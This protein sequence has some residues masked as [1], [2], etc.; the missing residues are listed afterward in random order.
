MSDVA[1]VR[2]GAAVPILWLAAAGLTLL[3]LTPLS[4]AWSQAPDLGHGWA[5]PLLIGYLLWERWGERPVLREPAKLGAIWWIGAVVVAAVALPM[6][7]LLVPYPEWP[8]LVWIYT[9]LLVGIGLTT[10][11]VLAACLR[12]ASPRDGG[13][14]R[15]DD[16]GPDQPVDELPKRQHGGGEQQLI[17][18]ARPHRWPKR[19]CSRFSQIDRPPLTIITPIS[20]NS[21]R[22]YMV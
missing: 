12:G 13:P 16:V 1:A 10:A 4:A 8:A 2:R 19:R 11:W 20:S 18:P 7:L 15:R 17:A 22:P 5:A 9:L 21:S 6:Q 14:W 3:I